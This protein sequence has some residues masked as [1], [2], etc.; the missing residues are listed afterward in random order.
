MAIAQEPPRQAH[1]PP[2]ELFAPEAVLAPEPQTDQLVNLPTLTEVGAPYAF[3]ESDAIEIP[4]KQFPEQT[5]RRRLPAILAAGGVAIGLLAGSLFLTKDSDKPAQDTTETE[6]TPPGEDAPTSTFTIPETNTR[7]GT[8]ET[9]RL[10]PGEPTITA[11]LPGE[12]EIIIPEPR[13]DGSPRDLYDSV[14][15]AWACYMSSND[16]ACRDLLTN[17][18]ATRA[19]E[20][21]DYYFDEIKPLVEYSDDAHFQVSVFDNPD[22]PVFFEQEIGSDGSTLYNIAGG[23]L[24]F[25]A[26]DTMLGYI[27]GEYKYGSDVWQDPQTR[28]INP[29]T[30][31][32][33]RFTI[34]VG[35]NIE[36]ENIVLGV[37][38]EEDLVS[39]DSD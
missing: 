28:R 7:T 11:Q 16:R 36:G 37:Y 19:D 32:F 23:N 10:I 27:D 8:I 9:A 18:D 29:S 25:N 4:A 14:L 24:Y 31:E 22:N 13:T 3:T 15:A 1:Q 20:L 2:G 5:K 30:H 17:G 21:T 33:S 39:L 6:F 26:S 34:N 35:Q 12:R 38:W